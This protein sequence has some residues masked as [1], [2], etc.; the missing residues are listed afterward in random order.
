[1]IQPLDPS[2]IAVSDA[3]SLHSDSH[4]CL[5]NIE[6]GSLKNKITIEK[7]KNILDY[8]FVTTKDILIVTDN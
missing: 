7:G 3:I 6:D 2:T 1:M 4:I 5:Y 8:A